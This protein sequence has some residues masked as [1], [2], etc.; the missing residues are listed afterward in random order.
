VY[1]EQPV[2][3]N[4]VNPAAPVYI[5]SGIAGVDAFDPFAAK[6]PAWSAYRDLAY[7]HGFS[8]VQVYAD[9]LQ[10][11]QIAFDGAVIDKFQISRAV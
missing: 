11:A 4:Y 7:R 3:L 5:L 10:I 6:A 1:R 8:N 9:R 2:Q